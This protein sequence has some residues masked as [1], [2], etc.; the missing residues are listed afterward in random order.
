MTFAAALEKQACALASKLAQQDL[1]QLLNTPE[2]HAAAAALYRKAAGVYDYASEQYVSQLSGD[3]QTDRCSH[4]ATVWLILMTALSCSQHG[5]C[6]NCSSKCC[7][8]Q[9]LVSEIDHLHSA[10]YS[11]PCRPAELRHG[12]VAALS[13]LAQGQAQAITA[14]RAQVKNMMPS[15][16]AS[17]FCGATGTSPFSS[18]VLPGVFQRVLIKQRFRPGRLV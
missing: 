3:K 5:K 8:L 7:N 16:L 12:M 14:H 6:Q 18:F 15:A 1:E 4:L 9:V 10:V 13:K 2:Q 11:L 17:L